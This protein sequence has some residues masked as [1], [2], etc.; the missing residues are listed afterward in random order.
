M[1][2]TMTEKIAVYHGTD[3]GE[4]YDLQADPDE[5]VNLWNRDDHQAL[6]ADMMRRCFDA[7]VFGMDPEPP[8]LG[9]F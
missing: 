2:R 5:F 3:Q 1:L 6:K 4:L 7:S 8:R 9:P